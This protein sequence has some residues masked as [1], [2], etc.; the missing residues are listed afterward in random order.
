MGLIKSHF[1]L[2]PVD[3]DDNGSVTTDDVRCH[4]VAETA[5]IDAMQPIVVSQFVSGRYLLP[6]PGCG[7]RQPPL[8]PLRFV[9]DKVL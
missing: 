2:L 9:Y 7:G 4:D 6:I 1:P 5:S 3:I 8:H